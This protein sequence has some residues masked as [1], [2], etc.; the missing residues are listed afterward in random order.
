MATTKKYYV[1]FHS[2]MSCDYEGDGSHWLIVAT[3]AVL[4]SCIVKTHRGPAVG[5]RAHNPEVVGSIPTGASRT[6][7][8]Y[9]NVH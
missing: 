6:S 2:L 8:A 5:H 9:S 3:I 4:F 7:E 1:P